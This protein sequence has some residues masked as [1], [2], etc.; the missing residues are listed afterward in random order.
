MGSAALW[1]LARHGNHV[2]GVDRYDPPHALGS[3][4]GRTRIIREA[5]FEHPS[6]VPLVRRAYDLWA[7]TE[8]AAGEQLFLRTRGL[9][10]GHET[11]E[12]VPGSVASA[13]EHDIP[14]EL[15]SAGE[16]RKRFPALRPDDGMIALLERRAGILFPEAIVRAQLRLAVES[17]A[18][19]RTNTRVVG[20]ESSPSG[21]HVDLDPGGSVEA[22]QLVLAAGP[23]MADLVQQS[24]IPL[25]GERQTTHWFLPL[26]PTGLSPQEC[27][28][29]IWDC[30]DGPPFYTFPDLGDGVKIAIHHGGPFAHPDS[31]DRGITPDDE[32]AVR[33]RLAQYLPGANG[34]LSDAAV[35]IYT[36]T[37]DSHFVID[38]LH[39]DRV[40]VVSA[41]SGHG[42]KFASAVGELV[43]QLI[44][45][46]GPAFDISLFALDR[47]AEDPGE[48]RT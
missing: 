27:P 34:A 39:D 8:Q 22:R 42:F 44:A 19:L 18:E 26:D 38:W 45:G 15:L 17:G 11:G 41:C 6:Y 9:M 1:Q 33:E 5:Y 36:N 2:L 47:F 29:T 12:I 10:I 20:W 24:A 43:A 21:V 23:W 46:E 3:T 40:L 4:H 28:I 13:R 16:L 7:E 32:R 37:T 48:Q 31:I 25:M 35:C 14:H 30:P